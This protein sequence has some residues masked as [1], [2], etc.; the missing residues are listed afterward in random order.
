MANILQWNCKGLRSRAEELKVLLHDYNPGIT[1]LQEIKLGTDSFN[2]GLNYVLYRSPPPASDRAKGGA[3]IIIKKSLQHSLLKLNTHL[4][5][6]AIQVILDRQLTI[7]SLYLPPDLTFNVNDLQVLVNQLPSPFLIL[8]DFNAHNPLWGGDTLDPKGKIIEDFIDRNPI[9]LYNDGSMTYFNIHTNCSSAIDLSL[10]SSNIHLDFNWSVNEFLNGSDHY[11]IHLNYVINIPTDTPPKWKV[12]EADW[13]KYSQGIGMAREFESFDSHIDAY[14]YFME[15]ILRSADTSI[16]KTRGKP[17]RPAVPWWNKTCGILRK[18]TRRCYRRH[19]N[20]GSPQTK[21]IYKRALAK[22]R[23]H[24]KKSK[25]ASWLYYINGINSKTPVSVVWRKIR[26]LNGKFVPSPLP[27]L[28]VN[29]TLITNPGEVSEQLGEHF[30]KISS[31]SNYSPEF[32]KIRDTHIAC[33][34]RSNNAEP[35]NAKFSLR[36]LRAALTSTE[37]TAPGE[38]TILYEMLKHLP[39]DAKKFLLKIINKIWETGILPKSWK[40]AIIIPAQKPQKDRFQA[41][42]YRP[43]ALTSCVC[44]LMEKMINT[45]LVW[46][47]E[48]KGLISPLQFGFRKNR[49]TLDPL[50]RLSNEIQQGFAKQCQTIG[51]FF[52]LEKAYDTTWR[53]GIIKELH[54]MGIGGN[55]IRFINSFLSERYIKVRVGNMLSS[56]YLQEEGIPQGS[57]LSVTCFSVAI[58]NIVKA[59]SSPV[60]CSLFVDDFVLYC[61]SYDAASA[62]KY[63]QKSIDS[64]S[65]WADHNGFKFSTTKTVAVRFARCRR[66]EVVPNLTLKGTILPYEKEVKFLGLIFD[67]KL[68]WT[69]HIDA[70]KLRVK[71]S[72]S[73]L[74]VVSGFDWGADKKSLLKLYDSLC[75]SKFDY[76]CQIYSSACK[77]KLKELDVVHNMGLRIC[78][79][80]FRTSPVESIYVDTNELPLQL[81]REEQGLRYITRTKSSP[82]NPSF[83]VLGDCNSRKFTGSRSSKPFQIRLNEEVGDTF[84]KKQK[85]QEV[86]YSSIPPWFIPEI[87]SC[88]VS[89]YKKAQS[90]EEKRV[91][92]YEHNNIHKDC[93]KLFTDGSKSEG[94][95]G[96]AVILDNTAHVA[97]LPDSASVFTA[98][99][100]AVVGALDLIFHHKG[101]KYVIYSDSKSTIESLKKFATFHPLIQ[102]A[103]EW[104]FR[105]SCRHKSVSFC[106]VPSHVGIRGNEAADREAKLATRHADIVIKKVPHSDLKRPIRSYVLGKWQER[107]SSPLLPNNKKYQNIRDN[108]DIWFSS[109]HPSRRIEII[110]TRLRIGHTR[111]THGFILDGG[112]AP[113]CAHCDQLLSVEHILVHCPRYLRERQKYHLS[114]KSV[115]EILDDRVDIINLV[116]FLKEIKLFYD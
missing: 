110:L 78:S 31:P 62:C 63:L 3:A 82:Q 56:P 28:K 113:E 112:S 16:P 33:D 58:N 74:K 21:V 5:A 19:K 55:M 77:T 43:I 40:I 111:M 7:C 71:K 99:L 79:G 65:R 75:R 104:L 106:W 39:E 64:V 76:G 115:R 98:E 50:L 72:L 8:G 15:V 2:P 24:F 41:T 91:N 87:S 107:W 25:R 109:F 66:K 34:F 51:V 45:R 93:T 116:G 27:V 35:Y 22:Q 6:V 92:F 80:A 48:N 60:K 38:D 83:K 81:R 95:V 30:S 59:V 97:K 26:K 68:T 94:G 96:C 52:D 36:E 90:K 37:T 105:I 57:V 84:I 9:S 61:T 17:C 42:S 44:K 11:P 100:T 86:G 101:K 23:R 70:L 32:R 53:F 73:I 49:S 85:V 29:D 89:T 88:E 20:S 12:E 54:N 103:Q 46:H 67:S 102:K 14:E 69:S 108:I 47:L 114:G 1:C 10:C 4:Q 18:I 13:G